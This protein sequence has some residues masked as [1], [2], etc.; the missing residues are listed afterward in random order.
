MNHSKHILVYDLSNLAYI[1]AHLL[2]PGWESHPDGPK[3]V[4]ANFVNHARRLYRQFQPDK[5]VFACDS[6]RYWRH[7]I[8][9]DYKGHR[10]EN[11]LKHC[12]RTA[13]ALFKQEKPE[14]CCEVPRCEA[15][16]V[17]Y[18]LKQV[19]TDPVTVVSMDGDFFQLMDQRFRLYSPRA[20]EYMKVVPHSGFELFLKCIRGD[21]GD[22]IPSAYPRI[23]R[24]RLWQAFNHDKAMQHIMQTRLADDQP[25]AHQYE[26]NRALIDLSQLPQPLF[27]AIQNRLLE[28]GIG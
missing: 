21:R 12:V 4:M 26:L 27:T 8:F 20:K 14:L 25:V 19:T 11:Q 17:I 28:I 9:P 18:V 5:V 24:K 6:D 10:V 1:N 22:N 15:D 16:D 2:S 23:S 7:D 3:Q 13:I